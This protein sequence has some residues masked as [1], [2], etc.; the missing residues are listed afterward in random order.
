LSLLVI[1]FWG[2]IFP[3]LSELFTGSKVTVGPPFYERATG[4]VWGALML[5]MG[6]APLA[7]WGHST[8]KT[9][10]RAIWKPALAA[11]LAP[12]L[13][14]SAGITNWIAL[15]GFTLIALV[16]TVSIREFWRGARARSR[17]S[18]KNFFTELWLLVKRNR[19]RY[20]GYIIHIS[21]VLMGIGIIGI[22]LFQSDTQRHISIGDT[23]ELS[24]YTLRYDRLDQ[25][26]H[27][28]GRFITRGELTLSKDGE[29]L[30]VLTPRFDLYPD[31]QPMTIP[32]VRSTLVDDV[33][34]ILVNWEG[35]TAES[36]PFKVYHNPL[37]KWVWIGGYLFVFGIFI[38][39][40]KDEEKIQV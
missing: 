39:A 5:L 21:M 25:F 18:G 10:G 31:G 37:V 40:W 12:I 1:S 35:I 32:A 19:R 2:V 24:G 23:I 27:E 36:T 6:I 33:Y 15:S 34:V 11:L 26:R 13:A 29:F 22:E 20:G 16:I 30:E 14:L 4:P 17:K 38:A 28:D 9:L 7:A 3:L 8:L